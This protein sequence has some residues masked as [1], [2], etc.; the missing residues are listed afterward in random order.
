LFAPGA[1]PA[2]Q[3]PPTSCGV[4][5][6]VSAA[7]QSVGGLGKFEKSIGINLGQDIQAFHEGVQEVC[8]A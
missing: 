4:G 6:A 7:T 3:N 2:G 1:L 8:N 5:N